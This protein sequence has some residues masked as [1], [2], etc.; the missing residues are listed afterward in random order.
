M[1]YFKVRMQI[2]L[3][4]NVMGYIYIKPR[5]II[6]NVA[7]HGYIAG[8][9]SQLGNCLIIKY[10]RCDPFCQ[11]TTGRKKK[12]RPVILSFQCS[13]KYYVINSDH[14][15]KKY[16]MFLART[17]LE[18]H[19]LI[20]GMPKRCPQAPPSLKFPATAVDADAGP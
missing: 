7:D 11:K 17:S 19:L 10:D 4:N 20:P 3:V 15:Q 18:R 16:S 2:M 6:L 9:P 12:I 13:S 14:H 5:N 1:L 8:I